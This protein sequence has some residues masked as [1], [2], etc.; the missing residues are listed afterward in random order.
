MKSA[1][2]WMLLFLA[3]SFFQNAATAFSS[4]FFHIRIT[5][6][7]I[8]AIF[9]L[10]A[11][12]MATFRVTQALPNIPNRQ[13]YIQHVWLYGAAVVLMLI[14][15]AI[16]SNP[17]D[18]MASEAW[19]LGIILFF[20][21]LGRYDEVWDLL[22]KPMMVYFFLG[23]VLVIMGLSRPGS[24]TWGGA[25]GFAVSQEFGSS[26][27]VESDVRS[28]RTLA[29]DIR[30]LL[31]FWP[32]L[33]AVAFL[34]GGSKLWRLAG[35]VT[36]VI[37]LGLQFLV[38]KFRSGL[39]AV[40]AQVFVIVFFVPM[41]RR[42]LNLGAAAV[43]I[44][45]GLSGLAYFMTTEGYRQT[46]ERFGE[47]DSWGFRLAEFEVVRGE[48]SNGLSLLIGKGL[49]GWYPSPSSHLMYWRAETHM[50]FIQPLLKGGLM[51]FVLFTT[52]LLRILLPKPR[53]WYKNPYN[54][55]GFSVLLVVI[56]LLIANPFPGVLSHLQAVILGLG[57]ARMG[58]PL[59]DEA[60]VM[61]DD[62]QSRDMI[63]SEG[64]AYDWQ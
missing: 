5:E 27:E 43:V 47:S 50:G 6:G 7:L 11:L 63:G 58:T 36:P 23:L 46:M 48:I 28:I 45:V 42:K 18:G 61:L 37:C 49:A 53:G 39:L 2:R 38:F 19:V 34:A 21:I 31:D 44:V 59:A 3:V 4:F 62:E 16:S 56:L 25:G 20:L 60:P 33:F 8:I 29:Y 51:F 17:L 35:L 55:A 64:Y 14:Y 57:C 40:A 30:G 54:A 9:G 52:L 15:G 41:L 1:K 12:A 26:A 10:V 32:V 22:A 24:S 13:G